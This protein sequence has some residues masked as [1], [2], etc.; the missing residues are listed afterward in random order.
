MK[1]LVVCTQGENRSRYLAKYLKKKGYDADYAG[2]NPKGINPITQKKVGLAD[3]IITVR[4]HIK[5]KFLKRFKPVEKEI[6]N[7]EVK[8][9]PKRFSKE[10]ERLAEKSW[11]EFQKKYVYSELRKQIE[12]HLHK[13][14]KK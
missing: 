13:F 9:N 7:L 14:N 6:I 11:S 5:E 3:M 2:I 10:A 4:K 8:D 1:I 12:K